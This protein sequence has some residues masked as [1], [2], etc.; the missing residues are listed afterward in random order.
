M[1]EVKNL[2][3]LEEKAREIEQEGQSTRILRCQTIMESDLDESDGDARATAGKMVT[4]CFDRPL[5]GP[6]GF[7]GGP[8]PTRAPEPAPVDCE[9]QYTDFKC[10][11]NI[12]END[13]LLHL[14]CVDKG[15]NAKEVRFFCGVLPG[16]CW[17]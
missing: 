10:A 2:A 12:I 1:P 11:E 4:V 9:M 8:P 17:P 7:E 3:E 5:L 6:P 15:A 16:E 13:E 14:L